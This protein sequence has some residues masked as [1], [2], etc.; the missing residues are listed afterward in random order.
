[1]QHSKSL[2]FEF[3]IKTALLAAPSYCCAT[4][5][6]KGVTAQIRVANLI[7]FGCFCR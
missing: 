6:L 2:K 3:L 1:M 4:S 5:T 7:D